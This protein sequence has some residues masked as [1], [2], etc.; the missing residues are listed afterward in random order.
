MQESNAVVNMVSTNEREQNPSIIKKI[1]I[2]FDNEKRLGYLMVAPALLLLILLVAYPFILSVWLSFTDTRIAQAATGELIGFENYVKLWN[3]TIFREQVIWNT[4]LYTL[5]AVPL[6]LFFGLILALLLN[7]PFPLKNVVRGL[8]LIP[9]VLPTSLS[10]IIFRWL[11]EP[12]LSVLNY[13]LEGAGLEAFQWLGTPSNAIISVMIV[14]IWRGTPFFAVVL[15]AALQ[16]VPKDQEEA[17]E[18]DGANIFQRFIN[19]TVPFIMPVVVV[20]TLFSIIR[21][22][23]EMEIVW[24]LTRGGPFNG[25]H[26]IGTYAYQQAIQSSRI[27]E[28][29]AISLFFFP[30]LALIVVLQLWYLQREGN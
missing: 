13:M 18:I 4:I 30:I 11:F 26:M 12:T 17:A 9:W 19:I 28:G 5:G 14:N 25:T 20:S 8:I 7:R 16:G 15:L 1:S 21:T 22:F 10:M 3:R 6:K 2:W 24:V 29:A 23:A 27:G